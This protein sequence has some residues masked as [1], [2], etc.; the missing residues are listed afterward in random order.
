M[1][2][3]TSAVVPNLINSDDNVFAI[4]VTVQ[5]EL[6]PLGPGTTYLHSQL[7]SYAG[8]NGATGYLWQETDQAPSETA[9]NL[10]TGPSGHVL[11]V[12]AGITLSDDLGILGYSW[13]ASG[14][15]IPPV[16]DDTPS[17]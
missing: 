5:Q 8:E 15:G 7:L 6:Y 1:G 13:E 12:L 14:L 4:E 16:N 17:D 3:G 9:S 11:Q 2:K 10:G